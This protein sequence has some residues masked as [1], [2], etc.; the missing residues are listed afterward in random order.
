MQKRFKLAAGALTA[1]AVLSGCGKGSSS[2]KNV[3]GVDD[4]EW[5]TTRD[6]PYS[7][8]GKLD[9]GCT[10]TIVGRK[11]MLTAAH[12][13]FDSE[14]QRPRDEFKQFSLGLRNGQAI[15]DLVPVR[16]WIGTAQPDAQQSRDWALVELAEP[17]GDQVGFME[18]K[19]LDFAKQ[20]PMEVSLAGYNADINA[21]LTASAHKKCFI[22]QVDG[23][24]LLHDCDF[25]AGVAGGPLYAKI[26]GRDVL[27]GIAVNE[28]RNRKLSPG[29]VEQWS[30]EFSNVGLTADSFSE[31]LK[32]VN[33]SLGAMQNEVPVI[34]S[35]ILIDFKAA[36][37][38]APIA[39]QNTPE[40]KPVIT[41]VDVPQVVVPQTQNDQMFSFAQ[42]KSKDS[43]WLVVNQVQDVNT[44]FIDHSSHLSVIFA[45]M[46]QQNFFTVAQQLSD[47]ATLNLEN[48]NNFVQFGAMQALD[49]FDVR[50]LF[51]AYQ[52]VKNAERQVVR[53]MMQLPK[54][55]QRQI[56]EEIK[57]LTNHVTYYESLIFVR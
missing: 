9:S 25:T 45:G 29:Q 20:M 10:G 31:V 32:I 38:E 4:R 1:L 53:V 40:S 22:H 43:L 24:R 27:V 42:M 23:G 11:L 2:T 34:Q 6:F 39:P 57:A 12:C 36:H 50:P 46:T 21:G 52:Q 19:S 26:D 49:Q 30:T 18:V 5:V 16:A 3:Y 44:V 55:Q 56:Q 48:W 37:P 28:V 33:Q 15:A 7:M 8:I 51:L 41:P 14:R 17:I 54:E 35:A 13:V 47:A